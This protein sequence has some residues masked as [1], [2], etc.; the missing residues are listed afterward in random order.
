[1]K[2]KDTVMLMQHLMQYEMYNLIFPLLNN[3]KTKLGLGENLRKSL[4]NR[5]K[6]EVSYEK[7]QADLCSL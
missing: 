7:V 3:I 5:M 2:R 6:K 1:M 4:F